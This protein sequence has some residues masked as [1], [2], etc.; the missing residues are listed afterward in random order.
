MIDESK[1]AAK[2][3]V[4]LF[5]WLREAAWPLWL[6]RGVDWARRGFHEELDLSNLR[7]E[8]DFRRLRV[9]ARQVF[10]FAE[11]HKA[12]LAGAAEAVEI[13]V[14]FLLRHARGEEALSVVLCA[15]SFSIIRPRTYRQ[16]GWRTE[17]WPRTT[18][19]AVASML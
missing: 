5:S 9:A 18:R 17:F 16:T 14:D 8:V 2:E 13:G 6:E 15:G 10:V 7:C 3:L 11:A 19:A 1:S 12:G 4:Q